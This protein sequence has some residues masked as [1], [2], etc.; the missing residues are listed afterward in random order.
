MMFRVAVG[1]V[2]GGLVCVGTAR[3]QGFE[4]VGIRALGMGGAFVAVADDAS[5]TYWNPAGLV[6]GDLVSVVMET[7][8]AQ[9]DALPA[10]SRLGG[11]LVALGTWPVGATFY[12]LSSTAARHVPARDPAARS[13]AS[14]GRLTT[15]HVGVNV[16]QTLAPGLHVGTTLKY[17]HGSAG[18]DVV[19]PSPGDLLDAAGR[20]G[21]AGSQRFDMDAGAIADIKRVKL[22]LTV[23]NLFEP[24]FRTE[25]AGESLELTRQVR[26]G[27]AV[28]ATDSLLLSM[29]ADV[30]RTPDLAGD[31]RVL[32]VG[33]EQ[34]FWQQR[35]AV[36]GG[37]RLNTVGD[38][39]AVATLGASIAVRNG[40]FAD[41][42]VALGLDDTA[43]DAFGIGLRVAF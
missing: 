35:A 12:R 14:L 33:A 22:G 32:A 26:A 13:T 40:L 24:S 42:Y 19:S 37:F 29:D 17:V 23:R 36:R 27:V 5:A 16:L 4:A 18:A 3:G 6:T 39:C 25:R 8:V 38:T 7:G 31:T 43:R 41:G 30:T 1:L 11:T 20:V 28:R 10:P 15:T 34:R 9:A 2:M 21:R